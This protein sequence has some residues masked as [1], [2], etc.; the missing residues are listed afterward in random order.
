MAKNRGLG[1]GLASLIP[2]G[3]PLE[4]GAGATFEARDA[5]ILS[6]GCDALSPNPYQPRASIAEASLSELTAS[7]KEHG[8]IQPIL[9]RLIDGEYQIVAGERRWRAA[10]ECGL[11]EIP[12][13][14]LELTD[15]QAMEL[16]LIENLQREDL[17]PVE[18]ARALSALV[19]KLEITHEGVASRIGVSR[20]A[21][22]NKLRLLQ[23]P[24]EVLN[25]IERGE[26]TEGHGRAL[27]PIED[28]DK[29]LELALLSIHKGLS[30]RALED[31]AHVQCDAAK[32]EE[33]FPRPETPA[34]ELP[35]EIED[36][37]RTHNL[38]I[39]VAG[40]RRGMGLTIKGLKRWQVQLLLEHIG[41]H[42]GE[43][44]PA[45]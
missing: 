32:Y 13:R 19:T 22:T 4:Q 8:V 15:A 38:K 6:L 33:A 5:P 35:S 16:A 23:L 40:G 34:Y 27:L 7:I 31:M 24:A 29:C 9:V 1:K 12:V 37:C 14:V 20:A 39:R 28:S 45:E 2:I 10:M 18:V 44:F 36:I 17:N 42:S 41:K 25:L 26:I 3:E 30:V 43:F 11:T 21:V